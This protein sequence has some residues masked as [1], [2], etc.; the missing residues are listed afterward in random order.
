MGNTMWFLIKTAFWFSLVLVLLPVF[1]SQSTSRLE[2]DPKVQVSDAVSAATGA[3]QYVSALCYE[4]PDVCVK[5]G[6]T[7]TALGY[8]AREGARVAYEFLDQQLGNGQSGNNKVG[9][10][11]AAAA[12]SLKIDPATIS[13]IEQAAA[14][15]PMPAK[16]APS[17][18]ADAVVTGTVSHSFI[19]VPLPKPA[20]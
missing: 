12:A 6:E 16:I 13:K 4:R 8:R 10:K 5:G 3:F 20:I 14:S 2:S 19:P 11:L 7:L 1:S 17:E 18:T 9:E 15:Q